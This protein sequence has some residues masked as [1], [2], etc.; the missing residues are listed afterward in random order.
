M[1]IFHISEIVDLGIEKEKKRRD[2]YGMCAKQFTDEQLISLFKQLRDWEDAHIKKFSD[3]RNTLED[4][5]AQDSYPGELSQYMQS[6]VDDR[7]YA[8]VTPDEFSR[9]VTTPIEAVQFGISFE[10]DAILFFNELNLYTIEAQKKVVGQLIQEE[11]Q[12]IVF[13][14]AMRENLSAKNK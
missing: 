12:H 7:L 9:K 5:Q 10:K 13:L 1:N 11:K 8:V 14:A 3:M 4:S 2:F 6:L